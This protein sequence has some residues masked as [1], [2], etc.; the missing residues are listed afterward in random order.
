MLP[1]QGS[2]T[3]LTLLWA[4][5]SD[6]ELLHCKR[7]EL[8]SLPNYEMESH[9]VVV[10]Q[11]NLIITHEPIISQ[12][13]FLY[14]QVFHSSIHLHHLSQSTYV[15]HG[16]LRDIEIRSSTYIRLDTTL[17]TTHLASFSAPPPLNI[18]ALRSFLGLIW[19]VV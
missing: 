3:K 6:V 17:W 10:D 11:S 8:A 5:E 19:A 9:T 1:F 14:H 18:L 7:K 15:S 16:S 13:L 4:L 12:M 2:Q